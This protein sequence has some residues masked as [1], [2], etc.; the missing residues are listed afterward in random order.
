MPTPQEPQPTIWQ[1]SWQ[2][3]LDTLYPPRCGLCKWL[4]QDG[5]CPQCQAEMRPL[6]PKAIPPIP[7]IDQAE[8]VYSYQGR[9][10][11][12]IKLLKYARATNIARHMAQEIHHLA[13]TRLAIPQDLVVPVPIHPRRLYKRGF[14]QAALLAEAFPQA[15][16]DAVLRIRYT[17]PQVGLSR[18]E[19]LTNLQGAFQASPQVRGKSVLLV[20][21]VI[22]T[23]GTGTACAE[24]LRAAGATSVTLVA[25]A[26]GADN[27]LS[28]T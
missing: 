15:H 23:G 4:G 22:T 19:R 3:L 13:Q 8:A 26:A 9:A 20:D 27:P 16:P 6:A 2:I 21:D 1:K 11:Q 24:A 7:L 28:N 14:N 12:A 10:A 18:E 5:V 17:R 25:Y